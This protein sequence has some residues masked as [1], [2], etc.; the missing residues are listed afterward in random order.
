MHNISELSDTKQDKRWYNYLS[1]FA[2][3]PGI[4]AYN[5]ANNKVNLLTSDWQQS[6][7]EE[8]V[9]YFPQTNDLIDFTLY[10]EVPDDATSNDYGIVWNTGDGFPDFLIQDG[11]EKTTLVARGEKWLFGISETTPG[12]YLFKSVKLT[13]APL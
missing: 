5:I 3:A 9:F 13:E 2:T 8:R 1:N 12:K 11:D 4:F 10:I 6:G 7:E